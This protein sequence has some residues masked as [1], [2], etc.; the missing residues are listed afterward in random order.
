MPSA[1]LKR[2]FINRLTSA[3]NNLVFRQVM[4]VQ[5]ACWVVMGN[6]Q[7]LKAGIVFLNYGSD[8]CIVNNMLGLQGMN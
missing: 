4:S 3:V 1:I 6:A 5:G 8:R 2:L 7:L